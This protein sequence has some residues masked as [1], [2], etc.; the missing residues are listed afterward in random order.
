M[1]VVSTEVSIHTCDSYCVCVN[2]EFHCKRQCLK[3]TYLAQMLSEML[4]T[5]ML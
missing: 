3:E 5:K 1:I 2:F 4:T